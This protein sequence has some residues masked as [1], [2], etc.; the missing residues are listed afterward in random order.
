MDL[1]TYYKVHV[2]DFGY[3]DGYDDHIAFIEG[4]KVKK[5][6][7]SSDVYFRDEM[8][9]YLCSDYYGSFVGGLEDWTEEDIKFLKGLGFEP[10][11]FEEN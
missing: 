7:L 1:K 9:Y 5:R 8:D 10:S 3:N 6:I 2:Y 4:E 11:D